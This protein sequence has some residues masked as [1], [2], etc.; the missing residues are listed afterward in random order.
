MLGLG[1]LLDKVGVRAPPLA[2]IIGRALGLHRPV[3][4]MAELLLK[5]L[6]PLLT[7]AKSEGGRGRH[8]L[9]VVPLAKDGVHLQLE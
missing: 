4:Q 5:P 3:D 9:R 8:H 2:A 1:L 6:N 7:R